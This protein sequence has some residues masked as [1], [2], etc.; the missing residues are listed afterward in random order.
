MDWKKSQLPLLPG[1]ILFIDGGLKHRED[2]DLTNSTWESLGDGDSARAHGINQELDYCYK[3]EKDSSDF[4]LSL[5]HLKSRL[6]KENEVH[7]FGLWGGRADH[8][9]A[10]FGE[11]NHYLENLDQ[12]N[13]KI[14]FHLYDVEGK[15]RASLFK[16]LKEFTQEGNFALVSLEKNN[17]TISGDATY[18]GEEIEVSP[19][20]S[21]GISNKARGPFQV[22]AQGPC[23]ILWE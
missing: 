7:L 3:P 20:S 18:K 4:A 9:L 1:Y 16:G 15:R 17:L 23:L 10:I 21:R 11:A 5:K 12:E 13:V 2:L 6:T 22:Q 8:Q 14:Q 19:L